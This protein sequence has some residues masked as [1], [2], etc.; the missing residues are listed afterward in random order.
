MFTRQTFLVRKRSIDDWI[1]LFY[2][3][4]VPLDSSLSL[5]FGYRIEIF[6]TRTVAEEEKRHY[7]QKCKVSTDC[8]LGIMGGSSMLERELH[9]KKVSL[10]V[11]GLY[12]KK[13]RESLSTKLNHWC[14]LKISSIILRSTLISKRRSTV[15]QKSVILHQSP[16]CLITRQN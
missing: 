16:C 14:R 4:F 8:V 11:C 3:K 5:L 15:N 9:S 13:S 6:L 7:V 1:V 10:S 2:Q 12:R